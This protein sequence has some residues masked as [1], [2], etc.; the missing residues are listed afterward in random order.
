M[1]ILRIWHTKGSEILFPH[2][3]EPS[4]QPLFYTLRHAFKT[5]VVINFISFHMMDP[6][7]ADE[8]L[9][10]LGVSDEDEFHPPFRRGKDKGGLVGLFVC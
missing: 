5:S 3:A 6:V 2:I 7:V 10:T 1:R 9:P 4:A 8:C